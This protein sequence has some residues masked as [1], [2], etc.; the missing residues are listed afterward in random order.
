MS[1]TEQINFAAVDYLVFVSLLVISSLIGVFF[2]WRDRKQK[3]NKVRS[4]FSISVKLNIHWILF[5]RNS[6]PEVVICRYFRS[7]CHSQ[8]RSCPQTLYWEDL[9]RS[10]VW[11][12]P[13]CGI[14]AASQSP[15]FWPPIF[16]C[17][18]TMTSSWPQFISTYSDD[19]RL[20]QFDWRDRSVSFSVRWVFLNLIFELDLD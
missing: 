8:R 5:Y 16:S 20:I 6:W 11:A 1:S 14:W 17:P 9:P 19:L 4:K 7:Q 15:S 12:L 2:G 3:D 18:S 10:T 13:T